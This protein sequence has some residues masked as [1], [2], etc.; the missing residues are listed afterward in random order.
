MNWVSPAP[1]S[2]PDPERVLSEWKV[3]ALRQSSPG[4]SQR[5]RCEKTKKGNLCRRGGKPG[6]DSIFRRETRAG[7]A[8]ASGWS[9]LVPSGLVDALLRGD[10]S[11]TQHQ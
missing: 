10:K 4:I 3:A 1:E 8:E 11:Y 7:S 9:I 5:V 2:P 6:L